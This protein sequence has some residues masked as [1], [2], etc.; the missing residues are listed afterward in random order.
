M[1]N[2]L[3]KSEDNN[4]ESFLATETISNHIDIA[5]KQLKK[6]MYSYLDNPETASKADKLAYWL[7]DY[8]R[9]LS[10]EDNFNPMFL[11]K[12]KRGDILKVNLG[13]NIGNEEGGLH[14]CVVV[15]KN[16]ARSSG[17][18]TVVPLTSY[19]GKN[20]HFS[21]VPLGNENLT[22]FPPSSSSSSE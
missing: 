9:L 18:I 6:L 13:Y 14:Y 1:N 5:T 7:E 11:K 3:Q 12:Y 22:N 8:N 16:N 10:F 15:D 4:Q 20:L 21:S 17:I 19:K 2:Q